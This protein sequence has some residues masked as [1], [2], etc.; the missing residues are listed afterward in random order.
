[1]PTK[2]GLEKGR[3]RRK[4]QVSCPDKAY[5]FSGIKPEN[6]QAWHK[7]LGKLNIHHRYWKLCE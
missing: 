7:L 1:M 6:A 4:K 3:M 5:A 2:A